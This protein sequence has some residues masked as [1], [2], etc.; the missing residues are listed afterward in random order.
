MKSIDRMF[1]VCGAMGL[2]LALTPARAVAQRSGV[3]VW[4]QTCGNC[5]AAQ[6][7]SRYSAE[8]WQRLVRHMM[9]TARMTDADADAVR[10][11]LM[12]SARQVV[13]AAADSDPQN[14]TTR[15]VLAVRDIE[16]NRIDSSGTR[17]NRRLV[18][19]ADETRAVFAYIRMVNER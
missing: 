8:N 14:S 5:H 4:A 19:T 12:S 11:F 18:L 9:I 10:Q 3:E 1:V 13:A 17:K 16:G 2:V 15:N 6:P 7:G